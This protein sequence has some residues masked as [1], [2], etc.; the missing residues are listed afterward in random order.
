MANPLL[1]LP[2]FLLI[3]IGW[4]VCRHTAL[5][6]PV[7]D[8]AE[9]LVYYLLFPVL[10]FNSIVRSPL[11]LGQ[12]VSLA[13]GG[14]GTVACGIALAFAVQGVARRRRA[15]A[16]VGCADRVPLQLVHRARAVRTARRPARPGLDG[17][18]DRAVRA[19]L[20]RR[21]GLAAGASRRPLV[22]PR[23]D[24]QSA[25]PQH[26]RRAAD[27]P[28]RHPL[29]GRGRDDLAT[30]RPRRA[31]ARPDGG[32]RGV[33][34]RR[35]E[36]GARPRG[37]LP[38][39]APCGV[40]GDRDRRHRC[41]RAAARAARDRRAV[42]RAADRLERLRAGRADGRRR[43]LRRRHRDLVDLARDDQHPGLARVAAGV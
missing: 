12:T 22:R 10:L 31:A 5:D 25:D 26:R 32:R 16:C 27:Q 41:A 9:R 15:P 23:A 34:A 1:L 38:G 20:Q 3:L 11:Q 4:A 21:R 6:R 30:H 2:D 42:R 43:R 14:L 36:G 8:A 18:R 7:W 35:P 39:A 13:I 29:S 24:A 37:D 40:A 19:A 28:G 17:A 33:A